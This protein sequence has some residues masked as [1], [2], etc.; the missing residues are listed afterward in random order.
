MLWTDRLFVTVDDLT[1]IDSEVP[2][3]AEAEGITLTG[4]RG[5]IRGGIEEA[6]F[7]LQKKIISFG[8]YLG[9]G[10]VT[11]NHL[12]AVLNVGLGNAVRQKATLSQIVVSGE[13][14]DSWNWVKQWACFWVLVNIYRDSFNRTVKDRYE[15]K[16]RYYQSELQRRITRTID[17]LGVPIVLRPLAAPAAVFERDTGTWTSANVSKVVGSG[18]LDAVDLDVAITYVDTSAADLYVSPSV[19]NNA[20]SHPSERITVSAETGK[21]LSVDIS[22]LNPPTGVQHPS[23][24]LVC[25]VS[26]MKA[27][28]WNVYVGNKDGTL[29]LQNPTPIP[30]G[31]DSYTLSGDPVLSGFTAGIGQYASR[32][33]SLVPT[34]QRA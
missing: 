31:T 8:G 10:D 5:L 13:S 7:E 15:G 18:T 24:V 14:E 11:P 23:Q 2:S 9:S 17:G 28:H 19:R 27:T 6:S 3:V 21:V 1:R 20:E 33:L 30:I 32:R 34:R 26:P 22:S 12:A 4:T 25:V 29:Y 16:M